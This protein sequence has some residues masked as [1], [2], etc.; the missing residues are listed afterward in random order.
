MRLSAE[1]TGQASSSRRA[2]ASQLMIDSAPVFAI[3]VGLILLRSL[4][5]LLFEQFGFDSDQAINGLMAKH[6]SHGR[7]FPLFFYGQ[8]YMLAVESWVAVPFFWIGGATVGTLRASLLAWNIGFAVLLIVALHRD[9]QLRWWT[10]LVP[11]LFFLVAPPSLAKKLFEAQGGDIEPFVYIAA[12][13]FLRRRPLWFGIV[14]GIGFRNRE[15]TMYAVPV[16]LVIELAS[17]ELTRSR[18]RDWLLSMVMFFAVSELIS[19]LMP[20]ADLAGPGTRGQLLGGFSGSQVDN[21]VN[22][23]NWRPGELVVRTERL[24]PGLLGWFTGAAQVETSFPLSDHRWLLFTAAVMLPAATARLVWLMMPRRQSWRDPRVWI[25]TLRASL[26]RSAFACYVLGVGLVSIITFI[27]A[28]PVLIG[29]SRYALLGIL[30]PVGLSG[31]LLSLEPNRFIRRTVTAVVV[32]WAA[33]AATDNVLLLVRTVRQPPPNP[34]RTLTNGLIARE[35][36]AAAAGYWE[37][38]IATFFAD[39][40]VRV[41]S[42]DFVRIEEYQRFL[43][44]HL[45]AARALE[46]RPCPDGE[47]LDRWYL[48]RFR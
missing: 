32:A 19:A 34:I 38:Y 31:A 10:A 40:H 15:F 5:Y 8:T 3:A 17:G 48:C 4:A 11:A 29:Y 1:F 28:K 47:R 26:V 44:A 43:A 27:A 13:W 46:H 45:G 42:T 36:P 24:V 16:L 35:I 18:A 22:R 41:A 7:A 33:L 39:E 14:L 23:L 20:Y 2:R 9:G 12:L 30:L 6:L 37:A 21:L 25:V